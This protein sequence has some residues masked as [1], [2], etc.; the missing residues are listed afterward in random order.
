MTSL[1]ILAGTTRTTRLDMNSAGVND[2]T[3]EAT[4][5][6]SVS[7][8]AQA[9]RFNGP[10]TDGV[11]G[12][13]GL[14]EDTAAGGRAI[15]IET[16]AGADVTIAITN[17]AGATVQSDDDAIQVQSAVT[18]GA[19]TLDNAGLV[20]ST[21]GQAVDFAAVAGATV[22]IGNSGTIRSGANDAIRT[23]SD[24]VVT[25][26]GIIDGGSAA[27]YLGKNDGVDFR[28]VGGSVHNLAGGD[29]SGDRHGINAGDNDVAGT[30]SVI[31]DAGAA[32]TGRN[33]SGVG[34]D[35]GGSVTNYGTITGAFSNDLASDENSAGAGDTPDGQADGDGDGV[36]FDLAATIV[37]YGTIQ[38]TGAGGHGSDGLANS[39][40]GIATGGGSITNHTGATIAGLGNGILVD[41]SSQGNASAE[42]TIVNDGT[43]TGTT[44]FGIKIVS[45]QADTVENNGT[46]GGGNGT[47]ILFG[48]GDN[49]LVLGTASVI[50]GLSDGGLGTNSLEYKDWAAGVAVNLRTGSASGTG[51]IV[52]FQNV[53]GSDGADNLTGNSGAN[54][55]DGGAGN[56]L[57]ALQ[58]GTD[59]VTEAAGGGF[60]TVR[61]TASWTL[62]AGQEVERL[63][64]RGHGAVD[65]TGNGL[66][67]AL[68]GNDAANSLSGGGGQDRLD[69]RAGDDTLSSDAGADVLDGGTGADAMSGGGGGDIYYV[70]DTADTITEA[71]DGG[72]DTVRATADWT[73][74]AGQEVERVVARGGAALDLTG[75]GLA[76]QLYGNGAENV[77]TGDGGDDRLD[78][79][80]GND[81]LAGGEGAD[82]LAG[83]GGGDI[84][85]FAPQGAAATDRVTDFARGEDRLDVSAF[86]YHGFGELPSLADDGHGNAVVT[87]DPF[88]AVILIGVAA[89]A[90]DGGDFLFA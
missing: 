1:T 73:I 39:S 67:N 31:N 49:R 81:R 43:I 84:F 51:G 57:Y 9:V 79:R 90:L 35:G 41:D 46:I 59:T 27:G 83:G 40:E 53:V 13:G 72:F 86:G 45:A 21:V 37:N 14:I 18:A 88:S 47:A 7:A 77:L 42:T 23:G 60:D 32:I 29:I 85:V 65:L 75:N 56:D 62:A 4:G 12:N 87:L 19:L 48:G 3:V 11:I 16:G 20:A 26:S 44:L 76:N 50:T 82:R 2:L 25:N 24:A 15:R 71:A 17:H 68:Y 33:G 10:T 69:G 89:A 58:D 38:G 8:N 5:A 66:A 54:R 52:R 64:A 70:D 22:T 78:G 74:G 55:F 6:I 63:V 28:A 36:D 61:T 34:S 30:I 80:G